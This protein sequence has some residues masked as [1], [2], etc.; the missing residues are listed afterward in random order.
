M[1]LDPHKKFLYLITSGKTNPQTTPTTDDFSDILRLVDAAV[2]AE[3]D[4]IQIREKLLSANVLYKLAHSAAQIVHG[5]ATQL[6]INDRADIAATAGADGVHLTS[7]SLPA[8]VVRSAFGESFLIGVSTHSVDEASV[9]R[10]GGA[11][12]VVF[13][14]ILATSSKRDYGEPLGFGRLQ[15]VTSAL[16]PFPVLALGGI[17]SSDVEDCMRAGA[18]GIAAIAMLNDPL[19]LAQVVRE[20]RMKFQQ[21]GDDQE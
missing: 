16:A 11:D 7:E 3:I 8:E 20:V 2:A 17:T 13:G 14:P 10:T 4:L 19:Q 18:S 5:S 12:F 21:L 9:A 6:L 15:K 1:K